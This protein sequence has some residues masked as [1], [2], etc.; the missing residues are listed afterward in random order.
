MS[1]SS[2]QL[3]ADV[4]RYAD[5]S[6]AQ[7][8]GGGKFAPT[9]ES[10]SAVQVERGGIVLARAVT[11]P[12]AAPTGE[13]EAV[14]GRLIDLAAAGSAGA[15]EAVDA[16]GQR[17]AMYRGVL[18]YAWL[19]AFRLWYESLPRQTFGRWDEALRA[20]C[21]VLESELATLTPAESINPAARGA[22]MAAAAWDALALH[23]AGKVFLRDAWTD[24]AADTFGRLARAGRAEG[25][26]LQASPADH[27]ELVWYH[28]LVI[29]HAAASYAVQAE[30]RTVART[31]R[32]A[33]EH[34]LAEIQPDHATAQP[35]G[36]F[37]FIWNPATRP[38]ADQL[39]H[40]VSLSGAGGGGTSPGGLALILL[41]DALYCLR[42]FL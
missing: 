35:W 38:L 34:H 26:F 19:S 12:A 28:E 25:T 7:L 29:L 11:S 16:A 4:R 22:D 40:A 42:L 32:R 10:E 33:T 23:V 17:R 37:A 27:P 5:L 2:E 18:V 15:A 6:A 9:A 20:W 8:G 14:V 1:G 36:L 39:L 31:V 13:A 24:L 41:A 3:R 21:D 30:D